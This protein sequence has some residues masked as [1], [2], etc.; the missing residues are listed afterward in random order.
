M[1]DFKILRH[2]VSAHHAHHTRLLLRHKYRKAISD[3]GADNFCYICSE[4]T[5]ARQR[6]AIT[7]VVKKAYHLYFGCKIGTSPTAGVL[8]HSHTFS[9]GKK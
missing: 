1:K 8:R 4:V 7:A 3:I 5:F 9:H 6:K 2:I